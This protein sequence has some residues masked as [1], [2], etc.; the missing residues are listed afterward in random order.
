MRKRRIRLQAAL[1]KTDGGL[2]KWLDKFRN[3]YGASG[4][5][6]D[7]LVKMVA[8]MEIQVVELEVT[9]GVFYVP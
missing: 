4:L 5:D 6:D 8:Y 9:T 7:M 2:A 3:K 1:S